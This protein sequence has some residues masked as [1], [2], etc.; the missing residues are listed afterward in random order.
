VEGRN[1]LIVTGAPGTGKTTVLDRLG[2]EFERVPEPAREILAEQRAMGGAGTTDHDPSV[3]VELLLRRSIENHE[4]AKRRGGITLFDR[5]VPDCVAYAV[6]LGVDPSPSLLAIE[7]YRYASEVLLFEPWPTIYTTDDERTM[8]FDDVLGFHKEIVS[9]FKGAG[10]ALVTVPRGPI[11]DRR[12]SFV[13]TS[14][15]AARLA[16]APVAGWCERGDSNSHGLSAT[17]S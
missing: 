11:E 13:A 1:L 15:T 2:D 10:Y 5:G 7:R 4:A 14:L 8:S 3:F 6:V 9:T 12:R 16:E 17:G